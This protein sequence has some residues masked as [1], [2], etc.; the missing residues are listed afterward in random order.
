[1]LKC[2]QPYLCVVNQ[3]LILYVIAPTN[4]KDD[5]LWNDNLSSAV[6]AQ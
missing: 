1:M 3:I 6:Q 4:D 2:V 5:G